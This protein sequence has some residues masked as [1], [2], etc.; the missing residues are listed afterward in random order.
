MRLRKWGAIAAFAIAAVATALPSSAQTLYA[1]SVRT[2]A[3][4]GSDAI[5]GS[6]FAVEL[7]TGSAT[8]IAPIRLNGNS[9]L[10]VT[11]LAVHPTSGVMYG[12]TSS[13]SRSNPLSLVIVDP[14]TGNATMVG[15]LKLSGSDIAFNKMGILFTW[16]PQTHQL[17][18]INLETGNVTAIGNP[19]S[20]GPPA[21]LA[22]DSTGT[23]YIT[24]KGA[25]GSVDTVDIATGAIK[26]G[27]PLKGAPFDS[28]I[29]SMAF[30]PSGLLLAVNSNQ[31]AP[32]ATRL[33]TINVATGIVSTIGHLPDD[34]DA[35]AFANDGTQGEK[36]T[37]WRTVALWTLAVIAIILGLVGF[38][39]G[40]RPT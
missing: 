6:L 27:P 3:E 11:G 12:I 36:A 10:G 8:L 19:G 4:G 16:L 34:T 39:S 22:I 29:N 20:A 5:G 37:D 25:T 7:K 13:L 9:P 33:V 28:T 2:L 30:T 18:V 40:R 26:I 21:G 23:A 17:G 31:G 35:L 1:A 32:A 24:A 15:P 14:K 38:L